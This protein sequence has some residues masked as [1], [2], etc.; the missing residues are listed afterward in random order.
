MSA[1]D[2][3]KLDAL[4]MSELIESRAGIWENNASNFDSNTVQGGILMRYTVI[5]AYDSPIKQFEIGID[6]SKV[7][8]PSST[9]DGGTY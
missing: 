7:L 4:Y 9:I 8:T 3:N 2:R 6:K 1:N 5:E